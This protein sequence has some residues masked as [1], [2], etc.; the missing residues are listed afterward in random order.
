MILSYTKVIENASKINERIEKIQ[1]VSGRDVSFLKDKNIIH[2]GSG[3]VKKPNH[4]MIVN[5]SKKTISIDKDLMSGSDYKSIEDAIKNEK[6]KY[7]AL[8]CEHVLEHLNIS[9]IASIF[10]SFKNIL[11]PDADVMVTIPNIYNFGAWF[12]DYEHVNFAP[13]NHIAS[14][15]EIQGYECVNMFMW[16]KHK[17]MLR[18]QSLNETDRYIAN[19]LEKEYGLQLGRY[20][21]IKFKNKE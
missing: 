7:D 13:P 6:I 18:H 15:I 19:F 11:K 9:S 20:V 4:E 10:K 12:Q 3:S 17:H 1:Y 16:S 5:L 2:F 8:V 21:T 14:I